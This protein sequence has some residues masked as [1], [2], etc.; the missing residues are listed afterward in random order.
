MDTSSIKRILTPL[1]LSAFSAAATGTA[2]SIAKQHSATVEGL[3]VLDF[4]GIVGEDVPYHAWML[5]GALVQ[6]TERIA[7]AKRRIAD[8][9]Q[10]FADACEAADARHL[11][12]THQGVP[13]ERIT[14]SAA[15]HDL[16]VM[17]LRTFFHFEASNDPGDTLD[18]VLRAPQTPILAVPEEVNDSWKRVLITFDGSP[19]ACRA[20][21]EFARLAQP[22]DVEITLLISAEEQED[23]A[24]CIESAASYLRAH[25]LEKI[26]TIATASDI[27]EVLDDAYLKSFNLIVAGSHSRKYLRDF[28]VGSVARRLIDYGQTAVLLN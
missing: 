4:P 13:A 20:L 5:P 11:N 25:H 26:E 23:G 21:K 14:E 6:S 8:A 3:V 18:K 16:L 12:S 10:L 24:Y 1:D 28:F 2:C 19:A 27:L 15:L 7:G 9:L 22:Y 17:G